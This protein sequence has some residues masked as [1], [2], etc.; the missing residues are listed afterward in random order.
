MAKLQITNRII[1]ATA[2]KM[3]WSNRIVSEGGGLI[4]VTPPGKQEIILKNGAD[5]FVELN[6]IDGTVIRQAN[7]FGVLSGLLGLVFISIQGV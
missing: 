5:P 3:G 2:E 1:R 6:K 7:L 4:A